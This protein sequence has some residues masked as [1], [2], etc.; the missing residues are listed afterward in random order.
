M[1]KLAEQVRGVSVTGRERLF[2][3]VGVQHFAAAHVERLAVGIAAVVAR[4]EPVLDQPD[5]AFVDA[6]LAAGDAGLGEA[7]EARLAPFAAPAGRRCGRARLRASPSSGRA[8]CGGRRSPRAAGRRWCSRRDRLS[9]SSACPGLDRRLL[10]EQ[11]E[12]ELVA[13]VEERDGRLALAASRRQCPAFPR[14]SAGLCARDRRAPASRPRRKPRR[15]RARRR[16]TGADRSRRWS[17]ISARTA[18]RAR[19]PHACASPSVVRSGMLD[20]GSSG[21]NLR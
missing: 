10:P 4:G 18:A 6:H 12:G 19:R 20:M 16:R 1:T 5:P 11:G 17:A 15:G 14:H 7:D 3:A 9:S 2:E 13:R 21:R 8:R